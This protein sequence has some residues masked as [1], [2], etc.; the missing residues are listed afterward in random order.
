MKHLKILT[1]IFSL[2][3]SLGVYCNSTDFKSRYHNAK[4][5]D[6]QNEVVLEWIEYGVQNDH[7]LTDSLI[8]SQRSKLDQYSDSQKFE[9]CFYALL[10]SNSTNGKSLISVRQSKL[11]PYSLEYNL[12]SGLDDC[13]NEREI[14]SLVYR[15][16]QKDNNLKTA[17]Q[18]AMFSL[19][20]AHAKSF[21]TD[22]KNSE[23]LLID[24]LKHA[25]RSRIK[26]IS[27]Y[28]LKYISNFFLKQED[29]ENAILYNQKG[30]D[31][32]SKMNSRFCEAHHFFELGSIQLQ[33][34]NYIE[35]RSYFKNALS[36]VIDLNAKHLEGKI[37]G[38]LGKSHEK[39]LQTKKAINYYQR[40]L[41]CFY[42]IED[43]SGV[44]TIHKDLGKSYFLNNNLSLAEKNYSLSRSYLEEFD[45]QNQLAELLHYQAELSLEMGDVKKA[46]KLIQKSIE[47]RAKSNNDIALYNSYLLHSKISKSLNKF[48]EAYFYLDKYATY[49][50][51]LNIQRTRE[52]LAELSK[53]YQA[54]QKEKRILEQQKEIKEHTNNQLIKEQQLE[55][56]QLKNKQIITILIFSI[57]LFI[58]ILV[59]IYFKTKQNKLKKQQKETELKQT[60]LRSQMNPHFIFN[61]MSIIQSY[62]YDND[63]KNSS[64]F[65]VNFSRLI[66]LILENSAK[67]FIKL[68][69][70]IEILE[71]YLKIQKNR[72]EERFNYEIVNYDNLDTASILIPPMLLQPFIENS[73]EHGELHKVRNGKIR[74]TFKIENDLLI[75]VIEDNG[76]GRQ[77]AAEKKV[78]DLN[79]HDSMAIDITNS[80][81]ELLNDKYKKAGFLSIQDLNEDGVNGTK[82]TIATLF[83]INK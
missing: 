83:Q 24:A 56:T 13:M 16:L 75:F 61:S 60:L 19:I 35:A 41:I 43:F 7:L 28:I 58:S 44:A 79:K 22:K 25:K 6:K 71:R 64:K 32:A 17:D 8:K 40:A 42:S 74:I 5:K 9:L 11:K 45:N 2:I 29:Y 50:D 1:L 57:V 55:N 51:S 49:Q 10:F 81:I 47:I 80:R 31:L 48:E 34:N 12:L 46:R 73:L 70:E 52:R 4:N 62:I 66:R 72:F 20:L 23:K 3:L 37:L 69:L 65:L 68:N 14:K 36:K 38:S 77:A 78:K 27:S 21:T 63:L 15:N 54:E 67:E 53:L 33:I 39:N 26:L 18:K 59:I 30:L 82:V 76:I